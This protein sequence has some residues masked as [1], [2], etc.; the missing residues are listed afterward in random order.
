M[1]EDP[2]LVRYEQYH[3]GA[4]SVDDGI[5]AIRIR[6]THEGPGGQTRG[7]A[8]TSR[9]KVDRRRR[10]NLQCPSRRY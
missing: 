7:R 8:L 3:V 10:R 2:K 6:F 4:L 5:V 1:G 9:N